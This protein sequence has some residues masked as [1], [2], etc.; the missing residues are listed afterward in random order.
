MYFSNNC[1][2]YDVMSDGRQACSSSSS[3]G[4]VHMTKQEQ[5]GREFIAGSAQNL[6]HLVIAA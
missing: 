1:Y 2:C 4:A 5:I 6:G 3:E